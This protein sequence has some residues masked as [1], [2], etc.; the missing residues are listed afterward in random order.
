MILRVE[1]L[2]L[3]TRRRTF[4]IV[5]RKGM[6][7]PDTIC[8]S[9]AE[10]I[11]RQLSR[12]YLEHFGTILHH[13][14]DK[15]TLIA[16]RAVPAFGGGD[17]IKPMKLV[18]VGRA[19]AR[20][21]DSEVPIGEIAGE[22]VRAVFSKF[23]ALDVDK[24]VVWE[25]EIGEGSADLKA[26]V[27]NPVPLANDTSVGVAHWPLTPTEETVLEIVD[28]LNSP[29]FRGEHPEV[30]E[31]IKVMGVRVGERFEATV[32]VAFVDRFLDSL[33]EYRAAKEM[34]REEVSEIVAERW[35]KFDISVNTAD[36]VPYITVTGLSAENGDDGAVGRGNKISG[37]IPV[38]KPVSME[39]IAGKNP[40]SHVG[41]LYN[42]AA[43]EL[44]KRLVEEGAKEAHVFMISRIGK[45]VD[46]PWFIGIHQIGLDEGKI[47]K[48]V[49]EFLPI[50]PEL[51]K[52]IIEGKYRLF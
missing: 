49:D 11:S 40:T 1:N 26:L 12:Y 28:H 4:E 35:E 32:A 27:E 7:H 45:P 43:L 33:E 16:G 38:V 44:A 36:K 21:E 17:V 5:E 2:G 3:E 20:V 23:H 19:T 13:N 30:G 25:N 29:T 9:V 48:V 22:A 39:A 42:V 18:L 50:I 52:D 10:E 46:Q 8:D 41:K 6:G 51:S 31:D 37:F 24:H 14:V 15:V 34:V 47:K